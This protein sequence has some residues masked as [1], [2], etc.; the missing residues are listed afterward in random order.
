MATPHQTY[1]IRSGVSS[2][3]HQGSKCQLRLFLMNTL[4]PTG[5]TLRSRQLFRIAK[6]RTIYEKRLA[7]A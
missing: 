7:S 5:H 2:V 6:L 3:F 1:F 4:Y